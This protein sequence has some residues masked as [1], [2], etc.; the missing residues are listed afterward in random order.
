MSAVLEEALRADDLR[1]LDFHFARWIGS[2]WGDGRDDLPLAAALLSRQMGEGH[3]CL[4]LDDWAGKAAFRGRDG[5]PLVVVPTGKTW[6]AA[7]LRS[8]AVGR[9]GDWT[10]LILDGTRLYLG[11]LWGYEQSLAASLIARARDWAPEVDTDRLSEGL[12]RLFPTAGQE[13]D[14]QKV[15][16]CLAVLKQFLVISGGPG[17]G[18]TRTVASILALLHEQDCGM[19]VALA[20]PTGKAAARLR[21][22]ILQARS[23]LPLRPTVAA[24]LPGDATTI[25]RLLGARPG[26]ASFRHHAENPL[27]LD[28][29]VV[30]EASM[31]DLPLMAKLVDALPPH[32]R[33]ILIG[34]KDQLASVEAGSVLG[35]LCLS[36]G[37]AFSEEASEMLRTVAR[38]TVA[39]AP[40]NSALA[41]NVV[42][43]R[44]SYRFEAGSGIE[45]LSNAANAGDAEALIAALDGRGDGDVRWIRGESANQAAVLRERAFSRASR[46]LDCPD[47]AEAMEEF[48]KFRILCALRNGPRGVSGIN[49]EI[50]A[51][52]SG[53]GMRTA[54]SSLYQGKPIMIT[55]NLPG[56]GLFNGDVG[57][58]WGD[59]EST[60]RACFLDSGSDVRGVRVGRLPAFEAAFAMTVHKS[61]GSEFDQ[62][63]VV[64]PE[65]DSRVLTRE[66]LYTAITR[67]RERVEIWGDEG[68]LRSAVNRRV[69]RGSGLADRMRAEC[70][71]LC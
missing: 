10:P 17:T 36:A 5:K 20:A 45:I 65:R 48:Q 33:L 64:L 39:P 67:A 11:R 53:V 43:L 38:Q 47:L 32:A 29:L 3:V 69:A 42:L 23:E 58:L 26:R 59:E 50:E 12:A 41:D 60:L 19:R 46:H 4:A 37:N 40:G 31:V 16:A 71:Q 34:D 22:S 25:H 7:L 14:W 66:L 35:D 2:R 57:L 21:E 6:A 24:A 27:A 68:L 61:Q 18:K 49:Q 8:K 55:R 63:M 70:G 13:I 62:V 54:G 15:A 30:D 9:P 28:T 51:L 1:P 44:R 52:R 56:V